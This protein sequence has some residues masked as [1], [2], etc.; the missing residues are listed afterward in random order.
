C[1]A[2]DASK[3]EILGLVVNDIP[4][5]RRGSLAIAG[6][7]EAARLLFGKDISNVTLA[8]AA[9]IAGVIQSPSALSPFN[10]PARCKERRNVVL[11]AMVESGFVT[12]D[13][14]ERASH[15]PLVVVQRA[16]EAEAPY[17]IDFVNQGLADSSSGLTT[18]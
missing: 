7:P 11:Q 10:N 18:K 4:L 15:E 14:A 6:V 16:L 9:T 1:V 3:V 8:E 2:R 17:F 5:G 13:L 12:A